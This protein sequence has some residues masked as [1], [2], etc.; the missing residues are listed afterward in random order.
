MPPRFPLELI[1][2]SGG[3]Q[4][5]R[6]LV[7][8]GKYHIGQ[9]YSNEVE[10]DE[11]SV[12]GRH[13]R[14]TVTGDNELFIEDLRSVNGTFVDGHQVHDPRRLNFFSFVQIGNATLDFQRGGL[15]AAVFDYVP[16]SFLH[17]HRYIAGGMIARGGVS[18]IHQARDLALERPVALRTM[19]PASQHS[20][21][22]VIRFIRE[23]QIMGQLQH[24]NIPPV[25]ELRVNPDGHLFYS[26]RTLEGDLLGG[27]LEMLR[28]GDKTTMARWP[29][30]ALLA[31]WQKACD[32]VAFA[33][34]RGVIH[35]ALRPENIIAGAYG[36]V[37]VL[38]WTF[39][40]LVADDTELDHPEARV[41]APG[42]AAMATVSPFTAPEITSG[43]GIFDDRADVYSLGAILY[44][45]L[46]WQG[47]IDD[48]TETQM[49][50]RIGHGAIA[51]PVLKATQRLANGA[52]ERFREGLSEI[53]L[54]ALSTAPTSRQPSAAALQQEVLAWQSGMTWTNP[55]RKKALAAVF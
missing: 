5:A 10:I 6:C 22:T 3:R 16:D 15:P 49:I 2:R 31:V 53:A 14:L 35:C 1:V 32:A 39:A 8:T 27:I 17:P 34:S 43:T 51:P 4:L 47:P 54:K 29:L 42:E 55:K 11:P 44:A 12:S 52:S 33:N 19:Q 37:L 25:H 23:A 41:R 30:T 46:A 21:A 18:T 48:G 40:V 13:A 45:L 24:P 9:H 38:G 20:P 28:L 36:D 7:R 26:T 50:R